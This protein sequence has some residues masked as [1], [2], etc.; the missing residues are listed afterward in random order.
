[1]YFR[2][3]HRRARGLANRWLTGLHAY[4]DTLAQRR[5]LWMV[6]LAIDETNLSEGLRAAC[7][8]SAMLLLGLF[9]DHPDFSWAAIGAFWTCLADAAG[10]RR[11][12]FMSM[13]GFGLLSTVV[14][15]LAALAAGHGLATAAIAVLVFSWAGALARIWGAATA[16]V[17]ILA[18]TASVVMVTHPLDSMTQ[19]APFL[20]LYMFGCLSATI[21][22]FTVWRIHPF[23][24]SRRAIR[25]AYSRLAGIARDNARFLQ[26]D[27][28]QPAGGAHGAS[29]RSQARAALEAARVALA[30][31]PPSRAGR[32]SLYDNLLLALSDAERIFAYLIAVTHSCERD[33]QRLR[34]DPRARRSLEVMA[35]LLHR[36][37]QSL[38]RRP[39]TPP[40]EWQRRLA[41]CGRRLEAALGAL[42]PLRLNVEFMDLGMPRATQLPWREA[43]FLALG[44]AWQTLKVN[45]TPQSLSWRH[46]ARVS[47]ATT[48][49]FLLVEALHIPFGYW[50]TMATLLILQP[51][52]STTWP[53][54]I[55][56]V[57]GSVLGAVLAVLIGLVIHTP[58]G[59]SL[60]VFPLIVATMALRR[61]SYSLHVLFMTPAFVLVA[62]Y[63]APA[64]EMVYALSRLGNNVLGCLL[65]LLATFFLWPDR[66]A[67][68]LDQ[69]LAK[70]VSAN[71]KYLLAVLA[72]GGKWDS[73]IARLRREAGL[74]SNNAEQVL[75][76][77]R[78]ERRLDRSSGV[79][80]AALR[81][82]PLLRRVAGSTARISLSPL[83]EPATPEL[84]RWIA[85]V[86]T[87]IDALL[88]GEADVAAPGPCASTGLTSLQA[89]AVAQVQLLRG[90]LR[91]HVRAMQAGTP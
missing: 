71:L 25:A 49:G 11:M 26:G 31:V 35:V 43:A 29:Y 23:G 16:Q 19:S 45:A 90:L 79:G 9:F 72:A 60:V 33:Q 62:D 75:Q 21:L 36:L 39:E 37:G 28:A 85:A 41:A 61:V 74:A 27:P 40:L 83:A 38:Q 18:A 34:Q 22:S 87:E 7:A 76:R 30:A 84:Q 3:F 48:A 65:A 57:A 13:V 91:E 24:P 58:L 50:A 67:D 88:R 10:T 56:R 66:E 1:M 51:S 82:L 6:T 77:L 69:R 63:A 64:S 55:E 4:T 47:L 89:D 80:L 78:I 59:I 12:R 52:V 8:S 46:A 20:G 70:A 68:D 14:G 42:L 53:R 2:K 86:S 44:Q 17:A 15:G 5:P 81:T 32:S 73:A 54:G